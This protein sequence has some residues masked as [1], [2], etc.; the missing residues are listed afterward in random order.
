MFSAL[1]TPVDEDELQK[2][3][4]DEYR[5]FG[6]IVQVHSDHSNLM[7]PLFGSNLNKGHLFAHSG[8]LNS[9]LVRF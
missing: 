4:N 6:D 8:D 3:I 5:E 2:K 7:C 1:G 9:R